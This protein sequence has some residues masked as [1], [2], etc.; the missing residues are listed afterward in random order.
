MHWTGKVTSEAF[1]IGSVS[2]AWYGIIITC[3]MILALFL[4]I[5]RTKRI[6][7]STDD[8]LMLFLFCVPLGVIAGRLGYVVANY[9]EYFVS[10]YNW[11]AFVNTIALWRGGITIMWAIPGAFVGALIWAKV[12]KKDLIKVADIVVPTVLLAQAIGRWGNFFNQ[13]L[14]GQPVTDPNLQWFPY[15][16][17][18]AREGGFYQATFFYESVLNLIGFVVLSVIVRRLDV[19]GVGSLGYFFWYCTV[20]GFLEI[21]RSEQSVVD[22]NT[23]INTVMIYCFVVAFVALCLIVFLI[24]WKKKKKGA[25]IWY[26]KGIPPLPPEKKKEKQEELE[27]K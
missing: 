11:D 17:Y 21:I 3:A 12:Y 9:K 4:S 8:M 25:R 20:R 5:R 19:K 18:I 10:P 13:E 22:Q 14:Y 7:V 2:V 6:N 1:H 24:V 23:K 15:A 27:I 16:V 26:G